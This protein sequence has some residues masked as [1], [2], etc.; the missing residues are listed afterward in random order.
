MDVSSSEIGLSGGDLLTRPT[1]YLPPRKFPVQSRFHEFF[2]CLRMALGDI[3]PQDNWWWLGLS[4]PT[5]GG[6]VRREDAEHIMLLQ[7]LWRS[8]LGH[9]RLDTVMRGPNST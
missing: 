9:F 3:L 4:Y 7:T 1:C 6:S 8:R 2:H 5:L